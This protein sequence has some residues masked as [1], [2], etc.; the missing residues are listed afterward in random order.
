MILGALAATATFLAGCSGDKDSNAAGAGSTADANPR[1]TVDSAAP[2]IENPGT[3]VCDTETAGMLI[4]TNYRTP[5]E[6][7]PFG[8]GITIGLSEGNPPSVF[9]VTIQGSNL[10]ISFQPG[11]PGNEATVTQ[12][13]KTYTIRG[14]GA[15]VLAD[16]QADPSN[17]P[18]KAFDITVTCP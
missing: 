15:D 14:K 9:Q 8:Q 13:G 16:R 7:H 12:D 3:L 5:D 10:N 2:A 4:I 18:T 1:I 11:A 17:W 6:Q